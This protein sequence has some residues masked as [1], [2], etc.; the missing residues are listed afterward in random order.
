MLT[1]MLTKKGKS[2]LIFIISGLIIGIWG[3]L[4]IMDLPLGKKGQEYLILFD[5]VTGLTPSDPVTVNGIHVGRVKSINFYKDSVCVRVWIS[6]QVVLR[7]DACARI[8]SLGMIG[9]K[10]I[11]LNPGSSTENLLIS[12]PM[13]GLYIPDLADS[14]ADLNALFNSTTVLLK[15]LN[16]SINPI[17]LKKIQ[18]SAAK[19]SADLENMT[20]QGKRALSRM[21]TLLSIGM[22]WTRKHETTIDSSLMALKT[23]SKRFPVIATKLDS[24]LSDLSVITCDLKTGKGTAGRLL[25]EDSLYVQAANTLNHLDSLLTDV[26]KNPERYFKVGLINF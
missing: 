21:D 2:V 6:D 7:R 14:G 4:E 22:V 19:A 16:S 17:E 13:S 5:C 18:H 12:E 3:F 8:K 11:D 9:E 15:T 26:Q 1:R 10:Y 20:R 25:K 24:V 23:S